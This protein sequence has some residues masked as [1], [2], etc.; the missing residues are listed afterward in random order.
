M[1]TLPTVSKRPIRFFFLG[2]MGLLL[3]AC[4]TA[5]PNAPEA[6]LAHTPTQ[7][8]ATPAMSQGVEPLPQGLEL[9][10]R[11]VLDKPLVIGIANDSAQ[12]VTLTIP[13]MF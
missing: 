5:A 12:T 8:Q 9:L 11:L 6:T 10:Q 3:A 7:V 1:H 13:T 2:L 4:G